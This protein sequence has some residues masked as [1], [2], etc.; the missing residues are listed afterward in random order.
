MFRNLTRSLHHALLVSYIFVYGV[1]FSST[2]VVRKDDCRMPHYRCSRPY[3]SVVKCFQK[4]KPKV[5]NQ[6]EL[7]AACK[8]ELAY[9]RLCNNYCNLQDGVSLDT[10]KNVW[11]KLPDTHLP[12]QKIYSTAEFHRYEATPDN[13]KYSYCN[14]C[15]YENGKVGVHL[16]DAKSKG[17]LDGILK[18]QESYQP[19]GSSRHASLALDPE[20]CLI[21]PLIDYSGKGL[22]MD[23]DCDRI[24]TI[25]TFVLPVW[26]ITNVFHLYA[27]L[28]FPLMTIYY[29][30][31]ARKLPV[32]NLIFIEACHEWQNGKIQ[33]ILRGDYSAFGDSPVQVLLSIASAK[34]ELPIF[35]KAHLDKLDGKT[36]FLNDLHVGTRSTNTAL[37]F[38]LSRSITKGPEE[39]LM[40]IDSYHLA[41]RGETYRNDIL[42]RF[43][44]HRWSMEYINNEV[45]HSTFK[46]DTKVKPDVVL[47]IERHGT[48]EIV[49]QDRM[50]KIVDGILEKNRAAWK[51]MEMER[52]NVALEKEKFTNQL[53]LFRRTVVLITVHGQGAANT[54][55]LPPK[56][57]SAMILIMPKNWFGWRFLYANMALASGVHVVMYRRPEDKDIDGYDGTGS[58]DLVNPYRDR[59]ITIDENI[60]RAS[61]V[62][63][64]QLVGRSDV[65]K[66]NAAEF[67]KCIGCYY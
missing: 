2:S 55:F 31:Y 20:V 67:P 52:L 32:N 35:A 5:R 16:E 28:I 36:C 51:G 18:Q 39:A 24:V 15:T 9:K 60:F 21:R 10:Y 7:R 37:N 45:F 66:N 3:T 38:G 8:S 26:S 53:R 19:I 54:I 50:N 12:Q 64:V 6:V 34:N 46:R 63:A 65:G 58:N 47:I 30:R 17:E 14:K 48:R 1:Q 23:K 61:F 41:Q 33:R 62:N 13:A 40:K 29:D 11:G 42:N 56:C 43:R 59:N 25:P 27:D 4:M 49:N 22:I 44:V 57:S